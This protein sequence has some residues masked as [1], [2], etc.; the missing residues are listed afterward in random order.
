MAGKRIVLLANSRK[1]TGRCIA[2]REIVNGVV[3][4]TWIRPVGDRASHEIEFSER[5]YQD[6]TEPRPGDTLVLAVKTHAPHDYQTENWV[7]D[8]HYYW[9]REQPLAWPAIVAITESPASLW[10]N[11][12]STSAGFNDEMPHAVAVT[13]G[14]SLCLIHVRDLVIHVAHHFDKKRVQARFTHNGVQYWLWITDSEVEPTYKNMDDGDYDVGEACLTI[15]LGEPFAKG[16]QGDLFVYKLVAAV[17][18]P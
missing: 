14:T 12:R 3:Q 10:A 6:N 18:T 17:I 1:N 9:V 13:F 16:E 11:G 8:D 15:S 5:R 4:P 2:G 7:L